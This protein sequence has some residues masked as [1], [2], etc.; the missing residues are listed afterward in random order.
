MQSSDIVWA[1]VLA[2]PLAFEVFALL[3]QRRNP[4]G[5][6]LTFTNLVQRLFRL[7][8]SAAGRAVFLILWGAFSA[9]VVWHFLFEG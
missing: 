1:G 3:R 8:T 9:W 2:G 4:S 6:D 5:R 7:K